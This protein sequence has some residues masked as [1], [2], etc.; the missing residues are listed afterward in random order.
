MVEVVALVVVGGAVVA[1][2]AVVE[3]VAPVVAVG[4][5]VQVALSNASPMTGTGHAAARGADERVMDGSPGRTSLG[6]HRP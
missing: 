6:S 4:E 1:V 5:V 3:V 2:T